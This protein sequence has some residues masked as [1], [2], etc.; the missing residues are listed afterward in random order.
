MTGSP[1]CTRPWRWLRQTALLLRLCLQGALRPDRSASLWRTR[2]R[3][4]RSSDGRVTR[5]L[6]LHLRPR[7][8]CRRCTIF[9]T[10][11][12]RRRLDIPSR[13]LPTHAPIKICDVA[14]KCSLNSSKTRSARALACLLEGCPLRM[15]D[16]SRSLARL[17]D[18]LFFCPFAL[19]CIYTR[20]YCLWLYTD[21][22]I[23]LA[24]ID[25]FL[26][27]LFL[28]ILLFFFCE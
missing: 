23:S 26:R 1:C 8:P 10:F 14:T 13:P 28:F 21:G 5:L 17:L 4:G 18:V 9:N 6:R 20:F 2:A 15:H 11:L 24:C 12:R 7:P 25:V 19:G 16:A 22:S 27:Y 3:S